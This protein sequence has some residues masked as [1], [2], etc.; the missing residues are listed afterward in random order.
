[1]VRKI[2]KGVK[3]PKIV[4]F[5]FLKSKICRLLPDKIYLKIKFK[6]R[7]G[8]KLD[9]Q[10]PKTFNEKLQWLKLFDHNPEYTKM[11]DKY[12]VRK[13]IERTIGKQ[14]LIPLIGVYNNYHEIDFSNLPNQFVL[15]PNHTSG[16]V[17]V[18]KDKSEIDFNKLK[19]EINK[20]LKLRYYWNHRELPYK[21]VTPKIVCE[22]YLVDESSTELK[23]Y[24]FLCF[25]GIV[26]CFYV[27]AKRNKEDGGTYANYYDLNWVSLPF[28]LHFPRSENKIDKPM[29]FNKM[30]KLAEKLSKD[31]IFLRVD[32]YEVNGELYFGELTYYP[33]SGFGLLTPVS[34]DYELGSWLELPLKLSK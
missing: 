9:L 31:T 2:I 11:V 19:N 16:D 29:N 25:N 26:K 20:W 10:N 8:K 21:N 32:F 13:Y 27:G 5:Y 24:K 1:M 14:Y 6:L 17:F 33:G 22:K 15:K 30:V 3:N 7:M 18:C 23:D 4:I 34:Y 28:E 12:E